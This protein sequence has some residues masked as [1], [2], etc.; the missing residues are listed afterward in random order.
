MFTE[1]DV[2]LLHLDK[3]E[4]SFVLPEKGIAEI[5]S[6]STGHVWMIQIIGKKYH[7]YHKHLYKHP[8]H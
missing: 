7:L 6:K 3:F 1:A 5:K 8:Y 2:N 4:L